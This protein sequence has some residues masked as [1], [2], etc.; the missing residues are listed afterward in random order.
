MINRRRFIHATGGAVAAL[1]TAG[2]WSRLRAEQPTAG[3][4]RA[5]GWGEWRRTEPALGAQ[6]SITVQHASRETA[7]AA[8]EAAFDELRLVERLMSIY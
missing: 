2:V 8:L 5:V 1:G 3:V 7:E 4:E 6:V